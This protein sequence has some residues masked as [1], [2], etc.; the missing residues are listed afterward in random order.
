MQLIKIFLFV[1]LMNFYSFNIKV[2][3]FSAN[4]EGADFNENEAKAIFKVLETI[5]NDKNAIMIN[6]P[7]N[8]DVPNPSNFDILHISLQELEN[9]DKKDFEVTKIKLPDKYQCHTLARRGMIKFLSFRKTVSYICYDKNTLDAKFIKHKSVSAAFGTTKDA[10]GVCVSRKNQTFSYC[11]LSGHFPTKI[12]E[13]VDLFVNNINNIKE[14][15][16]NDN[17][18]TYFLGDI[19]TRSWSEFKDKKDAQARIADLVVRINLP[20][21]KTDNINNLIKM[22]DIATSKIMKKSFEKKLTD[23]QVEFLGSNSLRKLPVTY[24]YLAPKKPS[25]DITEE[26]FD[27]DNIMKT[28]DATDEMKVHNIGWLDRVACVHKKSATDGSNC[29]VN[30]NYRAFNYV[31]KGDHMPIIGWYEI[32]EKTRKLKMKKK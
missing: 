26:D 10:L 27:I 23:F 19:N 8:I 11:F 2:G 30:V 9:K 14:G 13:G 28:K 3:F 7:E 24:K 1:I 25:N 29:I 32:P 20:D 21:T 4:V 22:D 12:T 18:E 15:L 16:K 17:F 5:E 6:M 31:R